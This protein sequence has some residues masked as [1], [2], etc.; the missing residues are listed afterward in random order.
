[1]S[2]GICFGPFDPNEYAEV[3]N[4]PVV[5]RQPVTSL[6]VANRYLDWRSTLILVE[7]IDL[8]L[9]TELIPI[10]NNL[11]TFGIELG[12]EL[13][14]SKTPQE[15]NQFVLAGY[16]ILRDAGYT[17]LIISGGIG[18]IDDKTRQW[19]TTAMT[20]WPTDIIIGWHAYSQWGFNLKDFLNSINS[21]QNMMTEWGSYQNTGTN[22]QQIYDQVAAEFDILE[23]TNPFPKFY[24]Q[25]HDDPAANKLVGL[26]ASG[27]PN[28]YD[29][30][31][32]KVS[33]L[34]Q[35]AHQMSYILADILNPDGSLV[36]VDTPF[37]ISANDDYH[38]SDKFGG[39]LIADGKLQIDV[40]D[41]VGISNGITFNLITPGYSFIG[42]A[43][44][45][46]TLGGSRPL[47]NP[48]TGQLYNIT[49]VPG[50][51]FRNAYPP[52]PTR[53][54]VLGVNMHFR[55]G[56]IV[57]SEIYGNMPWWPT[58]LSWL[59]KNDRM[60]VYNVCRNAKNTHILIEIPNGLPL[61]NEYNQFYSPDKFG[62]L[63]WTNGETDL[64]HGPFLSLVDEVISQ[65]FKYIINMDER[66][67]NS[68]RIIRLV[69]NALSDEQLKYGFTMPG[70]DGVFYGWL[71]QQIMDWATAARRIKPNAYLGIEHQPG[72]IPVGNGPTD[73][74]LNG[75]MQGYD[76]ILGEFGGIN[77]YPQDN[78]GYLENDATW[79]VLGRMIR[80][81]H[82]DPRQVGDP[83]PPFY[84][85]DS[86]RGP[87]TY[88]FF[89][90]DEP[91][92]WV[93]INPNDNNAIAAQ[94]KQIADERAYAIQLGCK[95]IA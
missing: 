56:L 62:A 7:N 47:T 22:E 17:G 23:P 73:Y 65:G 85:I 49:L 3:A 60:E 78:I 2:K 34:F 93:R 10:K 37:F 50:N 75:M 53:I 26:R 43:L 76:I 45:P 35:P 19:L 67:P 21:Y 24:Y 51:P 95:F 32:R 58:A 52:V 61:Y 29:G 82:R 48:E 77:A 88:C 83:N 57:R 18:N 28:G 70:Y 44:S 89:E 54:E 80:P 68:A 63:D 79:Q 71:P 87:R 55:G 27:G 14:F 5:F 33:Q 15:F 9:V 64:S 31:W 38:T 46:D 4:W 74:D 81:Y 20:G 72:R 92:N 25:L 6:A 1:M 66:Q 39:S 13:N 86:P 8:N 41:I 69:M 36:K 30:P 40:P 94:Q 90:T 42:R 16:K 91:Y 11:N 12:N 59:N 84:L